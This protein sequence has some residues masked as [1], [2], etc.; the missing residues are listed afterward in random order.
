V[1]AERDVLVRSIIFQL[2]ETHGAITDAAGSSDSDGTFLTGAE[3]VR[4]NR[5]LRKERESPKSHTLAQNPCGL[6]ELVS[7]TLRLVRCA[8]MMDFVC[9]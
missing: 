8:W 2:T 3:S 4:G 9:K 1:L 7:N 6:P 5:L